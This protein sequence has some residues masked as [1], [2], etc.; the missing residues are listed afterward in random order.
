[1]VTIHYFF[2]PMCG[3][4]YG[5]TP[6]IEKVAHSDQFEMVYHPGGMIPRRTIEAEFRQHI[7]Q[8]D[9]RIAEKTNMTFGDAYKMRVKGADDL[10]LDSY[11]TTQAFIAGQNMG[12]KPYDMLKA[13]QE[14]HY[15]KGE[16]IEEADALKALAMSLGLEGQEWDEN[17]AKAQIEVKYE[18]ESSRT[19]MKELHVSGFP[20][21]MAQVNGE[22]QL[23]PM[24]SYYGDVKTWD[25]LL[26][27]LV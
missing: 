5:A 2:D 8:V 1:M 21:L 23:L 14:A 22:Y 4:C 12:V 15:Q 10:I 9:T 19:L 16:S 11:I 24:S 3:W 6:L 18:L 13:I 25:T 7:L 20:T 26:G 17:M 27:S